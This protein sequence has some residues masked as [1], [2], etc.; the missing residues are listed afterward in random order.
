MQPSQTDRH[1]VKE[2][3]KE[4]GCKLHKQQSRRNG[5]KVRLWTH[6]R[7][8]SAASP[9]A[10]GHEA[11]H[12]QRQQRIQAICLMP[13]LLLEK[14]VKYKKQGGINSPCRDMRKRVRR[15]NNSP[16][17][18]WNPGSTLTRATQ[19]P[20]Q[21]PRSTSNARSEVQSCVLAKVTGTQDSPSMVVKPS[22]HIDWDP[23]N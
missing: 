14:K 6:Y 4:H 20:R 17:P 9:S 13:L 2:A 7:A 21:S 19:S 5:V 16:N 10:R 8:A 1:N 15:Q 12:Q 23:R 18:L 22:T 3:L 11:P